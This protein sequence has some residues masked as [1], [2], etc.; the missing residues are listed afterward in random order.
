MVGLT[1]VHYNSYDQGGEVEELGTM[2]LHLRI[3]Q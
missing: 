2:Y 1:I 3:K